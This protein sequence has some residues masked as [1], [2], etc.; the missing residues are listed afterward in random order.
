MENRFVPC[1]CL[2]PMY[3][4]PH[5]I[6]EMRRR[7]LPLNEAARASDEARAKEQLEKLFGPGGAF[8]PETHNAK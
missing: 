4:E 8:A 3:G 7:G 1:A 2:G 5:C 6:C